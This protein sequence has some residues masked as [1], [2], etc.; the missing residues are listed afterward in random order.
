MPKIKG[1]FQDAVG[2]FSMMR[3]LSFIITITVMLIWAVECLRKNEFLGWGDSQVY[4]LIA[5][6][7]PTVLQKLVESGGLQ[8]LFGSKKAT[9]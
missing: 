2:N 6:I 4:I 8:F 3:L 1:F 5:C 9:K 7:V